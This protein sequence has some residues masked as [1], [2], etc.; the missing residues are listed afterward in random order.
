MKRISYL[1][2]TDMTSLVEAEIVC[3]EEDFEL[4]KGGGFLMQESCNLSRYLE[5]F[6]G[7]SSKKLPYA[8]HR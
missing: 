2:H 3:I 5:L 6:W 4:M 8:T 1:D 7:I